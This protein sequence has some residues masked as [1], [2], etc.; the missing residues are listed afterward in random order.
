LTS[1]NTLENYF[2]T[3][4]SLQQH[5][6]WSISDIENMIPFERDLY[7]QMLTAY[8]EEVRERQ[9]QQQGG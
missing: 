7:V 2:Y 6:K 3:I 1:N 8:L 9:R 4:F 5:H